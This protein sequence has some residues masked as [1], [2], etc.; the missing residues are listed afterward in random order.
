MSPA[1]VAA[2]HYQRPIP[3][4]PFA[5]LLS[6][7]AARLQADVDAWIDTDYAFLSAAARARYKRMS[8]AYVTA[9]C[10]SGTEDYSHLVPV[11]RFMFWA[12]VF[13]DYYEFCTADELKYLMGRIVTI[14]NGGS[15]LST[16]NGIFRQ[17][18]LMTGELQALMPPGWIDGMIRDICL[19]IDGMI[20]EIPYKV[21]KQIPPLEAFLSIR[22]LSIGVYPFVYLMQ[23]NHRF[24]FPEQI[25]RHPVLCRLV[26]L[27]S[28]LSAWLNDFMSFPK[29]VGRESEVMNL[30]LVVQREYGLTLEAAYT[31]ALRLHD[32]EVAEFMSLA[33][34]LPDFGGYQAAVVA[35]VR[36]LGAMVQGQLS[37][38]LNDTVRYA[39]GGY[40]EPEYS[41]T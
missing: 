36:L 6:P 18:Q 40:A 3:S 20:R 31:E 37:W 14:M 28:R 24:I 32:A 21:A 41:G 38:Y 8:I 7:H 23:T 29:E 33:A 11:N 22:E 15:L 5:D 9:R 12:T 1:T 17:A 26:Q 10:I 19:Y 4:Y 13:D 34:S 2:T 25:S 27:T 35:Y 39:P 30:V 16:E